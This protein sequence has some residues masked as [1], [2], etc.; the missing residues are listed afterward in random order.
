MQED[1]DPKHIVN[2]TIKWKQWKVLNWPNQ[3]PDLNSTEHAF[4]LLKRNPLKLT[5]TEEYYSTSPE[6][7]IRR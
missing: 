5:T 4:H 1:N 7:N 3:S 2:S 6:K